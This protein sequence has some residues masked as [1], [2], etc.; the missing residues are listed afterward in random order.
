MM[1]WWPWV[2]K[3]GKRSDSKDCQNNH[4]T[5]SQLDT[6]LAEP[7]EQNL[8][9][10]RAFFQDCADVTI[11]SFV[12]NY[13]E[14][15]IQ[16][17]LVYIEGIVEWAAINDDILRPLLQL[18]NTT[19][20]QPFHPEFVKEQILTIAYVKSVRTWDQFI[21]KILNGS[22][23]LLFD[24]F[25]E[26]LVANVR[27]G[28][29]RA[30]EEPTS[31]ITLSGPRDAFGESLQTNVSLIRRRIK[32]PNLKTKYFVFGTQTRTEVVMLYIQGIVNPLIVEEVRQRLIRI[33]S[34]GIV[35][36]SHF[37]ELMSDEPFTPFPLVRHTERPDIVT[38]Q[39]LEGKVALIVDGTP[40]VITLPVLLVELLQ[41]PED[42]YENPILTSIVRLLRF[43]ALNIALIL[44]SLYIAVTTF[45]QE[46][47]PT[48]LLISIAGAREG[49][50]FPALFEALTMEIAF[51]ILREAGVRLPRAAGQAVTIVGGLVVG[52]AA[53][54]TG[55]VS[56]PMV[57]I[58][59]LT[60]ICS[61]A[62]PNF[63][64]GLALRLIRFP[65]MILAATM[66]LFG[67][68]IG[69]IVLQIHLASL[70][71][72]GV[73]YLA[74][75]A[76]IVVSNLKDVFVRLPAWTMFTR[77]QFV[78]KQNPVRQPL[79]GLRPGPLQGAGDKTKES[80][81]DVDIEA[82]PGDCYTVTG[83]DLRSTRSKGRGGQRGKR[84]GN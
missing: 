49:V 44:P 36:S 53:V 11:R 37:G 12:I 10:L 73:P 55:I 29:H 48:Q 54:Q 25:A 83:Q 75:L 28:E 33:H 50:P 8:C 9:Q 20:V 72:F 57:I 70:R 19:G 22:A 63:S 64:L 58:V 77:P 14:R 27:G 15:S 67:I 42:Y 46:M 38:G 4:E 7:L 35:G 82:S 71:S 62:I 30:V 21:N 76:P 23:G 43:A 56:Q 60:G 26:G 32:N 3:R 78:A 68:I 47:V 6:S 2:S 74:S 1:T 41:S 13:R 59:A 79:S 16:V 66:G 52:Q 45:H 84:T 24:G 5:N 81:N 69:L 80:L 40:T 61:F 51:E 34:D 17:A 65:L 39:L 31:E 18:G